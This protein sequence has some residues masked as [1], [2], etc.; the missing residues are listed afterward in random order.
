VLVAGE[1]TRRRATRREERVPYTHDP[2]FFYYTEG[3]G[4]H[5]SR[6]GEPFSIGDEEGE[7]REGS[8][9]LRQGERRYR[10]E[11]KGLPIFDRREKKFQFGEASTANL[12]CTAYLTRK[13]KS[14]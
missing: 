5:S 14:T 2:V 13:K 12:H 4:G 8:W 6:T 1:E 9:S 7:G 11:A 10:P 3:K